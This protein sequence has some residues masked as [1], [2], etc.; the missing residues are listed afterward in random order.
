MLS[1]PS[2]KSARRALSLHRQ[3]ARLPCVGAT[4]HIYGALKSAP[5]HEHGN[6]HASRA[7][8]ADEQYVAV[9]RYFSDSRL[10]YAH[11]NVDGALSMTV[12]IFPRF[13]Y[14]NERGNRILAAFAQ[15]LP[16][17]AH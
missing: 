4:I 5:A 13:A 8:L 1:F 12:A 7:H 14:V 3:P 15:S 6:L 2:C 11:W 16:G 10:K 17:F 9:G